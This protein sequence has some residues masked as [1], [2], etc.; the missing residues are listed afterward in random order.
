MSDVL[1]AGLY[2]LLPAAVLA[3]GS[4]VP[5]LYTP[6]GQI[7]SAT[8]H[9]A[10]GVVFA[11]AAVE[12]LPDVISDHSPYE[13]A[14][15]FS[16]GVILMLALRALSK[17]LDGEGPGEE[18][19]S[20]SGLLVPVAIDLFIDGLLLGIGFA[21]ATAAGQLLTLALALEG[22]SL[23]VV[24]SL[25]LLNYWSRWRAIGASAALSLSIMTGSLTGSAVLS[26][27]SSNSISLALAFGLA[28]LL[29][30]VTEEL[31]VEAH[32]VPETT[33]T[34]AMFFAGF[35]LFMVLGML[36]R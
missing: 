17:R 20:P 8:Q 28:A 11:V 22:L 18:R 35:V 10:A 29:Y 1:Q 9:F 15:A 7:R 12:L 33:F 5:L 34:T 19:G 36:K 27:L 14:I 24:T 23:G 26:G 31:L 3:I 4:M 2:S 13:S 21:A 16:L 6:S 32:E 25:T 30:L